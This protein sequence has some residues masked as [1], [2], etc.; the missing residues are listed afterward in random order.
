MTAK[1]KTLN[2]HIILFTL[3]GLACIT[4]FPTSSEYVTGS[5]K[6]GLIAFP[7]SWVQLIITFTG[8]DLS[9]SNLISY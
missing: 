2:G 3:I 7:N 6:M 8:F 9:P 1:W 4:I 5:A